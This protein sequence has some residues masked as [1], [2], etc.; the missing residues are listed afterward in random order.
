[1]KAAG[2][3]SIRLPVGWWYWAV[4]AGVDGTPYTVPKQ[5]IKDLTHPITKFIQVT[6][7][8]PRLKF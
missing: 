1:M 5:S 6:L 4:D 8:P 2:L 7:Y 3:N